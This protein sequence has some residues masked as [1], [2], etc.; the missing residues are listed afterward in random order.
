MINFFK[1][2][3]INYDVKYLN[4]SHDNIANL[5]IKYTSFNN[6]YLNIKIE[7]NNINILIIYK[8]DDII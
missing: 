1:R 4:N 6:I 8:I 5:I 2:Y 3:L 7:V